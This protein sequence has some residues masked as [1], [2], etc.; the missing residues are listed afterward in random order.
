MRKDNKGMT[1]IELLVA[2]AMLGVVIS[3]F[4]KTFTISA[5]QNNKARETFR[6]TTVAQN[7]MEGLEA[8][9][10][11]DVCNQVNKNT[12]TNSMLY[13]PNGYAEHREIG[14]EKS[15][16]GL[17]GNEYVFQNTPTNKYEIGIKGIEEDGKLYDA[18]ILLDA[19]G[20]AAINQDTE[21]SVDMMNEA[22]DVIYRLSQEDDQAI[23]D[24]VS[25]RWGKTKRTF[26]ITIK[27]QNEKKDVQ[28]SIKVVYEYPKNHGNAT[29]SKTSENDLSV[30]LDDLNN[31]YIFYY[32]NYNSIST[33]APLDIFDIDFH[34]DIDFNLYLVKQT[35]SGMSIADTNY[36]ALLDVK[37]SPSNGE[38]RPRITLRTN[39]LD[40]L[41]GNAATNLNKISYIYKYNGWVA[42]EDIPIM[43]N[44]LDDRPQPLSGNRDSKN[45]IYK[46]T[47]EVYPEGTYPD[48]FD[49][50]EPLAKLSN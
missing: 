2:I 10:L 37:D 13:R 30:E 47:V 19:S 1:L 8:F 35:Y 17:S 32:P 34:G 43:L 28:V 18:K 50:K 25:G 7:L 31:L 36:H 46:T 40:D 23:M 26:F 5:R 48:L 44:F 9:S 42:Q 4:L 38:K 29:D 39:I 20:Y 21:F 49:E 15:G 3:P 33:E 45:L 11:E 27:Q 12:G 41:Y 22:T 16:N 14:D 24:D 6:A